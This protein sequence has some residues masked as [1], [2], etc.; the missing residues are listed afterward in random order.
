MYKVAH[1]KLREDIIKVENCWLRAESHLAS[2]PALAQHIREEHHNMIRETV[3]EFTQ[4]LKA[5]DAKIESVVRPFLG[6][7]KLRYPFGYKGLAA[8]IRDLEEW[9]RRLD[10]T[11]LRNTITFQEEGAVREM[12]GLPARIMAGNLLHSHVPPGKT[13]ETRL[14]RGFLPAPPKRQRLEARSQVTKGLLPA[15]QDRQLLKAPPYYESPRRGW[16]VDVAPRRIPGQLGCVHSVFVK[17]NI[18]TACQDCGGFMPRYINECVACALRLCK[19]CR[20]NRN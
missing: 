15:P 18:P 2:I 10:H 3:V 11:H 16:G 6:M 7:R 12:S 4:K 5:V 1:K 17:Q 8:L 19:R 9:C 13:S 20:H 14:A